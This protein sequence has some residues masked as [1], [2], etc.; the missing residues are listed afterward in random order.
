LKRKFVQFLLFSSPS[1]RFRLFQLSEQQCALKPHP[2]TPWSKKRNRIDIQSRE[3]LPTSLSDRVPKEKISIKYAEETFSVPRKNLSAR[4]YNNERLKRKQKKS[5]KP[6]EI[7]EL[8]L[9]IFLLVFSSLPNIDW[10]YVY[11]TKQ[12]NVLLFRS[13]VLW[14]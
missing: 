8:K 7:N 11:S 1:F 14:F 4:I 3:N 13:R 6:A 9:F 2:F 5:W 10:W 12:F